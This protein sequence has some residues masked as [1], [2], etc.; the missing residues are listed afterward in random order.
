[1]RQ[2]GHSKTQMDVDIHFAKTLQHAHFWHKII[3]YLLYSL[4]MNHLD[5]KFFIVCNHGF[6]LQIYKLSH[7]EKSS[8]ENS[9]SLQCI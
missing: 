3:G 4:N 1:M 5:M 6:Q 7:S 8:S 2:N 9:L